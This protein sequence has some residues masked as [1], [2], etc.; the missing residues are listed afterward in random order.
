[1]ATSLP[2]DREILPQRLVVVALGDPLRADDAVGLHIMGEL[3]EFTRS[4][5][6]RVE[7]VD[8]SLPGHAPTERL[9]GRSAMVLVGTLTR[10]SRPG[11]VHVLPGRDALRTR[12]GHPNSAPT[13]NTV[14]LLRTLQALDAL[15][16]NVTVVGIEPARIERAMGLSEAVREA[17]PAAVSRAHAAV[18]AMITSSETQAAPGGEPRL[19]ASAG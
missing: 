12:H 6:G 17:L 15:P 11:T 3:R 13:G 2:Q 10:G 18:E 4:W 1:M 5:L 19:R 16:P 8:A 14:S 9:R 7:F